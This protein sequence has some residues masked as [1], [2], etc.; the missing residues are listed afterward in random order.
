MSNPSSIRTLER[1]DAISQGLAHREGARALLALGSSGLERERFDDYSD[2]DF[3]LIVAP[4]YKQ[5]YLE[6]LDWLTDHGTAGFYFANT[7]DGYKF[8]Y[9]DGVFCEFAVFEEPE[10]KNAAYSKG[11]LMWHQPDFDVTLATPTRVPQSWQPGNA[12]WA[13]NEALTCL[14]VGLGRYA[15]GERLSATRFVQSYAIDLVLAATTLIQKPS[16]IGL[17]NSN[18]SLTDPFQN[19]RRYELRYPDFAAS[20][21][22]MIQ[23]YSRTPESA[24]AIL[25]FIRQHHLI[26]PWLEKHLE[27][28]LTQFKC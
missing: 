8:L 4:G 21:P 17:L 14:Y 5:K 16:P 12:D 13:F 18:Q 24:R 22:E 10:M 23:G 25:D 26:N 19:E 2:L 11:R 3:F 7:P 27:A 15:R 28:L 20:L 6:Q 9:Q 1:L